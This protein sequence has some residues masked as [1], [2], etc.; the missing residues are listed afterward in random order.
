MTI[1]LIEVRALFWRGWV[2]SKIEVSW[3]LSNYT[4][5][6]CPI[7]STTCFSSYHII[8]LHIEK[9]IAHNWVIRQTTIHKTNQ[10]STAN[11]LSLFYRAGFKRSSVPL[12]EQQIIYIRCG[13][14]TTVH[15][16]RCGQFKK[17]TIFQ[18]I[19]I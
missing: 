11:Q 2:P 19:L 5:I 17:K 1:V 6:L 7:V 16:H 12:V 18:A 13:P 10:P 9:A 4:L 14:V 3:V 8:K 15:L